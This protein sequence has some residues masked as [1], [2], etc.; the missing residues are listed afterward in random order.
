MGPV[1]NNDLFC[2]GS[3]YVCDTLS[4][5]IESKTFARTNGNPFIVIA[6]EGQTRDNSHYCI[7][8]IVLIGVGLARI[9]T[10]SIDKKKIVLIHE[11]V[12]GE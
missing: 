9:S 3:I 1:R 8:S 6:G 11:T 5:L 7:V 10:R 4:F 2:I 12:I